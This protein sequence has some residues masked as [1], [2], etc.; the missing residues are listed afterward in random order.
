M[1]AMGTALKYQSDKASC[2]DQSRKDTEAED[3]ISSALARNVCVCVGG[4]GTLSH[5]VLCLLES[6]P[7][8]DEM[9]VTATVMSVIMY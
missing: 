4:G 7:W 5:N 1:T 6:S 9:S 8:D 3:R 2:E